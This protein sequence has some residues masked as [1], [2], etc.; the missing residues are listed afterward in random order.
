MLLSFVRFFE[1]KLQ[2]YCV[3]LNRNVNQL[4]GHIFVIGW[5][6]LSAD[7]KKWDFKKKEEGFRDVVRNV[8]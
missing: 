5:I 4:F 7:M 1:N 2:I 8:H 3:C 6:T